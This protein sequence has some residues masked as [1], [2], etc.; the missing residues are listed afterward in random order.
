MD[1][2]VWQATVPGV[3]KSRTRQSD[4]TRLRRAKQATL[5]ADLACLIAF[6]GHRRG[7]NLVTLKETE[8]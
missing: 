6:S 8:V 7:L 2:E 4:W 3:T 5:P 1:R